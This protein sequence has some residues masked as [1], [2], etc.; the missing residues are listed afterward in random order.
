[1]ARLAVARL[2]GARDSSIPGYDGKSHRLMTIK[3]DLADQDEI[4]LNDAILFDNQPA[5]TCDCDCKYET[6]HGIGHEPLES[7]AECL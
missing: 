2:D 7:T 5:L 4:Q 6:L 1:V 3:P